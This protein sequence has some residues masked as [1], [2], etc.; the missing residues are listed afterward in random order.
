MPLSIRVTKDT[1]AGI[2]GAE[3]CILPP[4]PGQLL[5]IVGLR[6]AQ[7]VP[8]TPAAATTAPMRAI[9]RI[10]VI[11]ILLPGPRV[12][13]EVAAATAAALTAAAFIATPIAGQPL[14]AAR[15]KVV[16]PL[17]AM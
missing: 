16:G 17:A 3:P 8:V 15:L 10:L 11:L 13:M 1:S 12:R 4:A 5:P 14:R 6:T 9:R 7:S 2:S